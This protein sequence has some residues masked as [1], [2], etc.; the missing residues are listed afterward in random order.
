MEYLNTFRT[1]VVV[2]A[3]ILTCTSLIIM[4]CVTMPTAVSNSMSSKGDLLTQ[5][6]MRNVPHPC[7]CKVQ[8]RHTHTHTHT[9]CVRITYCCSCSTLSHHTPHNGTSTAVSPVMMCN[10]RNFR[11]RAVEGVSGNS[12]SSVE[13]MCSVATPSSMQLPI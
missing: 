8:C 7:Y 9:T 11:E 2:L 4:Y 3:M 10:L 1:S 13:F 5:K 12:I 6:S